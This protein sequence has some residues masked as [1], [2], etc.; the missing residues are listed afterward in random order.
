MGYFH[1]QGYYQLSGEDFDQ[2]LRLTNDYDTSH[3][4]P[5]IE[6]A[7]LNR[8]QPLTAEQLVAKSLELLQTQVNRI[9][10][11][12]PFEAFKTQFTKDIEWL[13]T[14]Q[15]E[16]FHLYSFATLR[17]LGA[18]FELAAV[19]FE[20]LANNEVKNTTEISKNYKQISEI[21]KVYQFQ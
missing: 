2:V 10:K 3:L 17:Q 8:K 7:K 6:I 1:A 11:L 13:K 19:Y 12:C 20:W 16:M 15:L 5:Y 21:A 4:P 14:Q 18:C 9:P